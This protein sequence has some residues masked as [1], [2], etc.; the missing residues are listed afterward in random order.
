ML[1]AG[2]DIGA[3]FHRVALVDE[4]VAVVVKATS[5]AEDAAGDQKLFELLARAG[6]RGGADLPLAPDRAQRELILV[7]MEASGHIG[8]T[9]LQRWSAKDMQ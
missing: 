1:V 5:F 8:K 6:A 4:A 9:C 3:E 2:I 7:V